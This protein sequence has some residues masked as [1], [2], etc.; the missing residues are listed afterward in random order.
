MCGQMDGCCLGDNSVLVKGK[1]V[2]SGVSVLDLFIWK[3]FVS[4]C[5]LLVHACRV[6]GCLHVKS[7]RTV[8][9]ERI[10]SFPC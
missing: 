4:V 7:P 9:S 3:C 2:L 10:L 1:C 5:D 8:R 6:L